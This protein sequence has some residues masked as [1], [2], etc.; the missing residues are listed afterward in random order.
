[1]TSASMWGKHFSKMQPGISQKKFKVALIGATSVGKTSI[2]IRFSKGDFIDVHEE[3]IGAAFIARDMQTSRGTVSLHIW[4][5]AG[6]ERYHSLIPK[7]TQGAVAIIIVFDITN[8]ESFLVAK[9]WYA[10]ELEN[11]PDK[12]NWYLVGNKS[13][14]TPK[15]DLVKVK[16]FA[17][18][19]QIS[20]ILASA[21]TGENIH[22]LFQQ[23]AEKVPMMPT[24]QEDVNL[25]GDKDDKKKKSCC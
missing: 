20:F 9:D 4:D 19:E 18:Q 21:L 12:V 5:T 3:T 11:H 15:V 23:I 1:M 6:Q 8:E 10:E 13:D 22:E 7:Y 17:D 16:E 24:E 14:L 2:V 25:N